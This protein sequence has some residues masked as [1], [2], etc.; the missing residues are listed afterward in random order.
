MQKTPDPY[1]ALSVALFLRYIKGR[2]NRSHEKAANEMP[3][4]DP[5][6]R[7]S[8]YDTCTKKRLFQG[9]CHTF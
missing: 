2:Y 1:V 3:N 9:I 5:F 8:Y 6:V 4:N 7:N